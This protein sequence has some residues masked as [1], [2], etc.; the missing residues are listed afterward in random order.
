MIDYI[1][2]FWLLDGNKYSYSRWRAGSNWDI[3]A[4][5]AL[6]LY[7]LNLDSCSTMHDVIRLLFGK[8]FYKPD[9][10]FQMDDMVECPMDTMRN[11]GSDCD[12]MAMLHA[13]C[14]E[15]VL[16]MNGTEAKIVSYLADPWWMS[17]HYCVLKELNGNVWVVQPQ[18]TKEAWERNGTNNQVIFGPYKSIHETVPI[19]ASWYGAKVQW[20]DIRTPKFDK[21]N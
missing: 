19:V 4:R 13:Q 14:M 8:V 12:G 1:A 21:S 6:K 18:P 16:G 7:G 11:G 17:H 2:R 9:A 20:Y 10:F 3:S 5:D 15:Y